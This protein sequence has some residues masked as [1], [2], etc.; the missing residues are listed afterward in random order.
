MKIWM[1]FLLFFF[2]S[3]Y[4]ADL[5]L[6]G[7]IMP[8]DGLG[9]IGINIAETLDDDIS[10]NI[11]QTDARPPIK[12]PLTDKFQR[13]LNNSDQSPSK[14][15]ILTEFVCTK[16]RNTYLYIPD[17]SLIKIAYSML[18]TDKIPD[19]WVSALNERF[20]AVIVPDKFLVDV[21][22]NCGVKIP[23]FVLPIPMILSPY[24]CH[25][26]RYHPSHPF[27]F[28]DASANKN[29]RILVEAFSKTFGNNPNVKLILKF[30]RGINQERETI[31]EF[32][33]TNVEILEGHFSLDEYINLLSSFDCYVNLSRGE[34]FSLIQR[35]ALALGI[36][37]IATNNTALKTICASGF[38]R[39]VK[40]EIKNPPNPIY[41]IVFDEDVGNQCDCELEDVCEAL[42]DVYENYDK[43][44]RK[45]EEGK[46]W[47]M[48]YDCNNKDLRTAYRAIVKPKEVIL[49]IENKFE[50]GCVTT[51]S[52]DLYQKYMILISQY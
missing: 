51:N 49:G 22:Q 5:A 16:G 12:Y 40:S 8:E 25:P 20:D 48:N 39:G 31:A 37:V 46:E 24:Y 33:L 34:G 3:S 11:I 36:P 35:E 30:G 47:V 44:L 2:N 41:K 9:K 32:G 10:I 50:K 7:F 18:E 13:C 4:S 23:V 1:I 14:V 42:K 52:K 17:E 21:Y 38:V 27:I 15:S 43:F 29:V 19:S 28:G 6:V 26:K 45:A